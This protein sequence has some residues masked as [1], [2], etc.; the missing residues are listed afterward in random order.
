[1]SNCM[2]TFKFIAKADLVKLTV[3][4]YEDNFFDAEKFI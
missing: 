4:R 1:M 2:K 3:A